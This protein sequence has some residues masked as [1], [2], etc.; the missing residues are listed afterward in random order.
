MTHQTAFKALNEAKANFDNIYDRPDPREYFR[1]LS[2]LDYIIPDLAEP[3]FRNLIST[4]RYS[5]NR[6]VKV[7]DIGCSYGINAA[8]TKHPIDT[9]RFAQRYVS[10]EMRELSSEALI[11]LDRHY[12]RSWPT[13]TDAR[14]VGLDR[15]EAAVRYGL[16]VGLLDAALST[17]LEKVDP[18]SRDTDVIRDVDLVISTGS[19]GYITHLTFRRLLA[20]FNERH[21]PWF[22][23]FVLRMFPYDSIAS[24]MR[25]HGLVTEKL[26]GVTFIQR[27]FHSED[28]A[29]ATLDLLDQM[30]IDSTGKEADGLLHAELYLSRPRAWVELAPLA[31]HVSVTSGDGRQYGRRFARQ[32]KDKITLVH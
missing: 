17:D 24:T 5:L 7:L 31:S 20:A 1:V 8:L 32:A 23:N 15:S 14:F 2:G 29:R 21:M 19:V 25:E 10:T 28:E 6:S 9:R 18:T 26:T 4:L 30:G 11:K 27:R 13:I 3:I 16:N 12:I 22:A